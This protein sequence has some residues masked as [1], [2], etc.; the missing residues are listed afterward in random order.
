MV[1]FLMCSLTKH[2]AENSVVQVGVLQGQSLPLI[3]SPNHE[4]IHG[5]P[6]PLLTPH[7]LP[8]KPACQHTSS[9]GQVWTLSERNPWLCSTHVPA[10]ELF[11]RTAVP[12]EVPLKTHFRIRSRAWGP[13]CPGAPDRH[14][15]GMQKSL[16]R[17]AGLC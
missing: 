14:P 15:A 5:P 2:L 16:S 4:G 12:R 10:P 6:D 13:G 3:F 7:G 8:V 9:L 11:W 17:Q 1:H